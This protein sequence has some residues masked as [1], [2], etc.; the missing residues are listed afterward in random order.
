MTLYRNSSRQS[1][2]RAY[3]IGKDSI[4]VRFADGAVYDYTHSV[5]GRAEVEQMK[6]LAQ[7]G[8]GLC[9]FISQHVGSRYAARR[10]PP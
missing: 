1:G 10:P 3:E 4:R 2:V 6:R 5:T 8:Q 9:T 7:A